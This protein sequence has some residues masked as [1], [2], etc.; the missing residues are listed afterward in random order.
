M[1]IEIGY[2]NYKTFC[3]Y[4]PCK[5]VF[6]FIKNLFVKFPNDDTVYGI[7]YDFHKSPETSYNILI[8][9]N[10]IE[11]ISLHDF[12]IGLPVSEA[13]TYIRDELYRDKNFL[14]LL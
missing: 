8:S 14:V 12:L 1:V 5:D 4:L 6:Y 13:G 3:S 9:S 11:I 7:K 2:E 10:E